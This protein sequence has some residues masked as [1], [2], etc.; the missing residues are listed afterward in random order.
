MPAFARMVALGAVLAFGACNARDAA[1]NSKVEAQP[2]AAPLPPGSPA[3]SLMLAYLSAQS[4][5][6]TDDLQGSRAVLGSVAKAAQQIGVTI[7][8]AVRKRIVS[9]AERAAAAGDLAHVRNAFADLSDAMLVW[10]NGQPNPA[11]TTLAIV[12][13]PMARAGKGAK[14]VQAGEKLRNPYFGSEMLECGTVEST[15]KPGAVP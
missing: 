14:W 1:T 11:A 2:A 5:L 15:F 9:S 7:D 8:D 3:Q 10:L 4:K 13:C 6:A 12:H